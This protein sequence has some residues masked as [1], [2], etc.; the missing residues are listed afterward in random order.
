MFWFRH[1]IPLRTQQHHAVLRCRAPQSSRVP[2]PR[3]R[4]VFAS[5]VVSNLLVK[6]F[7]VKIPQM[8]MHSEFLV[9][10]NT[11]LIFYPRH[12]SDISFRRRFK[13]LEPFMNR[14]K[15][16]LLHRLDG[17][18]HRAVIGD[19]VGAM[20]PVADGDGLLRGAVEVRTI[21]RKSRSTPWVT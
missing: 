21:R 11:P 14:L 20:E 13:P 15:S 3:L 12:S 19:E 10:H 5:H 4:C 1:R 8:S 9:I 6:Q 17:S 16:L 2:G 7:S 18:I